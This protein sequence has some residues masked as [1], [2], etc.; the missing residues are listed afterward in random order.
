MEYR[1]KK[2]NAEVKTIKAIQ[3]GVISPEFIKNIS[4]TQQMEF[5]GR[6]ISKGINHDMCYDPATGQPNLGAINDPRMGNT[7]DPE[8][9]GYCGHIE[10]VRP[11]YHIEFLKIVIDILRS[12]S[13]YT[14]E[15]LV[16]RE[17]YIEKKGRRN[18]KEITRLS[19]S[20][21][22]CPITQKKL[23]TYTKEGTK[24]AVDFGKGKQI[25]SPMEVYSIL[26]K[27]SDEDAQI[28]GLNTKFTRPEWLLINTLCVPPPH[29]RPS[30][31]MSS[32]QKCDDDLT[33]KLNEI[34]KT[35]LA[36]T[37]AIEKNNQ[38]QGTNEHFINQLES[39]LQYNV[40]TFINNQHPGQPPSLQRSGKPLK[41]IRE[42]L[43]GK[44]GRVRGNLM[45]KRVDFSARTVITADPNLSLDQVGVPKTVALNLTVPVV[46]TDYN[47]DKL[48]ELV[49]RGPNIHPGAKFVI[50]TGGTKLDLKFAVITELK[51]GWVVE[52]HLNDGDE[53]IF[54]RQP[55]LHKMSMMGHKAK[56]L[57]G[58]TF[59]LNL[60]Y[61]GAYNA[62]FDGDEMNLHVP[63]SLTARAE[64]EGLM[65]VDRLIVSPQSNKPVIGIIQDSLLSSCKMTRRNVFIKKDLFMNMIMLIDGW[66]H[67][68]PKPA[69]IKNGVEYWTGKQVFSLILPKTLIIENV[70]DIMNPYDSGMMIR[71]GKIISGSVDKAVIGKSQGGLIHILFNDFGSGTT[72]VFLNQVQKISNYWIKQCGFTVGVGDAIAS[73]ETTKQVDEI[74]ENTKNKIKEIIKNE[75]SD[76]SKDPRIVEE[77]IN[78]ELN[79]AVSEAGKKAEESLNFNNNFKAT[80]SAGSKGSNI[81]ISQIMAVVGQQN[82]EGRRINYGFKYRTLPHYQKKDVGQESRGFVENNYLKGLTP[83]EFFFHAMAGR[84]G[85]IDTACK[86]IC[87]DMEILLMYNGKTKVVKIGEWIDEYMNKRLN[88]VERRPEHQDTE[89]IDFLDTEEY[90]MPTGDKNGKTSWGRITHIT[91]HDPGELL[92]EVKTQSG[93]SVKVV[94]SRSL[95]IYNPSTKTFDQK[96]T[97]Q[98]K[99]GE[100]VPMI[101]NLPEPPTIQTYVDMSKYFPKTEYI[102]GTE[103]NRAIEMMNNC[104]EN[105]GL[106]GSKAGKRAKE[107]FGDRIKIPK[108]WWEANNGKTFTTPYTKKANLQRATVRSAALK[109]G[110]IYPYKGTR[111]ENGV[112][113]PDRFELSGENGIFIGLFLAEGHAE[114]KYGNVDIS[115]NDP[116]IR[117]FVKNWF[118]KYNMKWSEEIR[119]IEGVNGNIWTSST[120]RGYSTLLAQFLHKFLGHMSQGK[121]VPNEAYNAPEEFITGILNGYYSGDGCVSGNGI[122][123][124]SVSEKM[125]TGINVLCSRIGVFATMSS[126]QRIENNI[127]TENILRQYNLTIRGHW[128]KIFATKVPM[129]ESN[130]Q[131]KLDRIRKYGTVLK[132]RNYNT[133]E[134]VILDPIISI[135][136]LDPVNYPKVYD[137]TIPSTQNL[138][139]FSGW[140]LFDTAEVGYVQRRLVKALEDVSVK[141][142]N[143]VRNS[144]G[145]II[146]FLYGEDGIDATYMENIHLKLLNYNS[147]ELEKLYRNPK[148]LK[149][150]EF[151]KQRQLDLVYITSRRELNNAKLN[152]DYFPMPVNI[153]RILN[154]AR[155]IHI[156][157]ST[158]YTDEEMYNEV[159]NLCD[160]ISKIFVPC[161]GIIEGSE[162]FRSSNGTNLFR[163]YVYS[164]LATMRIKD[165][166]KQQLL[167]VVQDIELKFKKALVSAGEMC[168]ILAAQSIGELTTQ[169]TLNSVDYDTTLVIDWTGP[170]IPPCRPNEKIGKFIDSL[171]EKFPDD[172]QLQ[173]DGHTIWLPLKKGTAKALSVDENGTMLW[174]ELEAVTKHLPINKDGTKTL[175]KV[176][177]E[178]G[179]EAICTKA[180][181]FL[182]YEND[183]I[184][185]K[186][187]SDLKIGDLIPIVNKLSSQPFRTH[188]D[189]KTIMNPKECVFTDYMIEAKK[190]IAIANKTG[191][192]TPWFHLIKDKVPYNRGDSLRVTIER[193]M[194]A[195]GEIEQCGSIRSNTI[196]TMKCTLM[197]EPN[198]VYSKSWGKFEDDKS[199][200]GIPSEIILDREFGFLI[201]AYLA[202]GFSTKFQLGISNNNENY[203]KMATSW[204]DKLGISNRLNTNTNEKGQTGTSILIHS[205]ILRNFITHICGIGSYEKRVPEFAF[206]GPDIF[207]E[208]ILDGYLCG[209]G[210]VH[211][212]GSVVA[213]SRSKEL[214][215]GISLLLTRFN[216]HTTITTTMMVNKKDK[217]DPTGE[218]KSNYHLY[219]SLYETPEFLNIITAIDYKQKRIQ[220]N[221]YKIDKRKL[222]KFTN[223]ILDKIISIDEFESH[224]E[225][226]YDLTVEQ[227]RN[228]TT[229]N[230]TN[231]VD[232]FH[233]AGVSAKNVTLGVPRLKELINVTKKLKTPSLTMYEKDIM[234]DLNPTGQKRIVEG[235]RSSLEYKTLQDIIKSSDIVYSDDEEYSD[236]FDIINVYKDLYEYTDSPFIDNFLSLRLQF[237]SKDIEYVD[238]SL[239]EISKILE[240]SVGNG[241]KIICSDDNTTV[242]GKENLFIR[243]I[244][245]D[246]DEENHKEQMATLRKIEIFCMSIKIKGCEGINRVYTREAKVNR[247]NPEKGHYKESQWV[248]ETEGTNLVDTLEISS[249]DHTQTIS[250]NVIEIYE[251]FGIEAARQALI[252][253]LRN[254]L[255]FDG[256]YVNYRHLAVLVD[257]MTCRG[258]LTAMTRHGINRVDAGTLTKCSFEETVEVLTDAAAF[259]EI[260]TLKGISDNIMLGQTIPAGTG[261][262]DIIYDTDMEPDV[263]IPAI[264]REPTPMITFDSYIPSE[265]N[266][267]PLSAWNY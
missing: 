96:L 222:N 12:V 162:K 84:E 89:V 118:E 38:D 42:R 266:Y 67:N 236:D 6:E 259:G 157:N 200:N 224:Y 64:V 247:W 137:V 117:T 228:M 175:L 219:C 8:H 45:G 183:R 178:S 155:S 23:P 195:N 35:N 267:D 189:L 261:V 78:A 127:C 142:D 174:T 21:K 88:I 15:L 203:R 191:P 111:G 131:S 107:N 227:T 248:L 194:L 149:E 143:T 72:K 5:A 22:K 207:A 40:S 41:T 47:K 244:C 182:V 34:V 73:L 202:E 120:V 249:I 260:D 246:A 245:S 27:I 229:L 177:T 136:K 138:T 145:L 113:L 112:M 196:K 164:E 94:E 103:F 254:V 51:N 81:N 213:S 24:I 2:S 18:L 123:V 102:H 11:V 193:A 109:N 158:K 234:K 25:I 110:I 187:G 7:N 173:Q 65:M 179:R 233:Y 161:T 79:A 20:I 14:S 105:T 160:R 99:I 70:K 184:I 206:S 86:S 240:R 115:N 139:I 100:Y 226:V 108:G 180:K 265:P 129:I 221:S 135:T 201:G 165:L 141:Y 255:S 1:F 63:Q 29:V 230:G 198:M 66:D 48:L 237:S 91:R 132:H 144:R 262:M 9:P 181:S 154:F 204:S 134:D 121:Y 171:I 264:S 69:I 57:D 235:I 106:L 49:K 150:Y 152:D 217:K 176:K 170:G 36:L 126:V 166:N 60:A 238:T 214:R 232:S 31:F 168:G 90:Y 220:N 218:L 52:R 223:T 43:S 83:Q 39:L 192:K 208:G 76:T 199:V 256:S 116:I 148:L 101:G 188:I 92:Y 128:S 215:D 85:L 33:T 163:I 114:I 46:V 216:I 190:I 30:V 26:E 75:G 71:E 74:L 243:I 93:R 37:H 186:E 250:N 239:F 124:S 159:M 211:T 209:D 242:D 167:Y 97:S 122:L 151:I 68:I 185:P 156:E 263:K 13:N 4:V 98:V 104:M 55:S 133:Q 61:T 172:C 210:C 130:K 197:F 58:S 62:D 17:D 119:E 257:T 241:H 53:V 87:G 10:L 44:D 77:L 225:F 146:Q 54:N 153:S 16:D 125:I 258:S 56:I 19:K 28:L 50:K 231:I 3:F 82:V 80:V 251:E 147:V 252:N 95:L 253:E 32:S 59:R 205:T 212:N 169:L 140:I